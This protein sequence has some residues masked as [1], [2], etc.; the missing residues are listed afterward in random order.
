MAHSP[1]DTVVCYGDM[2]VQVKDSCCA[3]SCCHVL[4]V[5]LLCCRM[6]V[7][8][9]A[10]LVYFKYC[11]CAAG[12]QWMW[13]QDSCT[14]ST[15]VVLQDV[16]GCGSRTRVLQ[17][18]LLCCRMSV[19]V[20]AGLVYFKYCCCAARYQWMWKQDSCTSSTVVVL[21]DISGCGSRTRVLQV[22]LLCCRI[23][24]DVEAGLMYFKYCCCA[25]GYQWMW[26]Q[27]SCTSSCSSRHSSL[28]VTK[29]LTG[30]L[31]VVLSCCQ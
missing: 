6:S 16:S 14:S 8:V 10:G 27:D 11:C 9:E 31:S 26:K 30:S 17:V 18:L 28:T 12:Y 1:R 25:A 23:S 13:K 7:D 24:V 19:D 3:V 15:V 29:R 20:E 22:L 2:S 21:Q 4:Q 5:L